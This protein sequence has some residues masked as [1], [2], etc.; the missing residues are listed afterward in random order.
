MDLVSAHVMIWGPEIKPQVRL[1][2]QQGVCLRCCPSAPHGL[3]Q[4]NKSYKEEKSLAALNQLGGLPQGLQMGVP[5][6]FLDLRHPL[7]KLK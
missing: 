4:I 3:S 6:A 5:K 2:D 7:I 1:Y